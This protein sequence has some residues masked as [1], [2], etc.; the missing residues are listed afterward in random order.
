MRPQEG[1]EKEIPSEDLGMGMGMGRALKHG[2]VGVVE[3]RVF[4]VKSIKNKQQEQELYRPYPK[5]RQEAQPANANKMF[6]V[7]RLICLH[8]IDDDDVRKTI[9]GTVVQKLLLLSKFKLVH[10]HF[11]NIFLRL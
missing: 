9:D 3:C 7:R 11:L 5:A 6:A 2:N 10:I 1:V 8:S 4:G